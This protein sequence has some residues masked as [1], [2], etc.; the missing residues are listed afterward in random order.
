MTSA[1]AD[2]DSV[3]DSQLNRKGALDYD[4]KLN[5]FNFKAASFEETVTP[6]SV[7]ESYHCELHHS[8]EVD[9]EASVTLSD[10]NTKGNEDEKKSNTCTT[11]SVNRSSTHDNSDERS[12]PANIGQ[13]YLSGETESSHVGTNRLNERNTSFITSPVVVQN[14]NNGNGVNAATEL[15]AN[16]DTIDTLPVSVSETTVGRNDNH[17]TES[18]SSQNEASVAIKEHAWGQVTDQIKLLYAYSPTAGTLRNLVF[19]FIL[20]YCSSRGTPIVQSVY[21]SYVLAVKEILVSFSWR[22]PQYVILVCT[23]LYYFLNRVLQVGCLPI[24]WYEKSKE[25]ADKYGGWK[26]ASKRYLRESYSQYY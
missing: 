18:E 25:E 1:T 4:S 9:E 23:F 14:L 13:E 19:V 8:L 16:S 7:L 24:I 15:A 10:D 20:F 5:V 12:G 17:T 11:I 22:R 3:L 21:R 26:E 2:C 6:N